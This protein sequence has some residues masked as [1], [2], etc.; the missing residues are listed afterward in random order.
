MSDLT[1]PPVTVEHH[2]EPL[3]IG[4]ATPRLSWVTRTDLPGWRQAA[5]ELEIEPEDGEAW[6]S[7]RVDSADS[8][9][10]PWGAP[11]LTS[12]ERRTVRV[13][14][15]GGGRRGAVGVERGRRR[16]GRAARRR[17]TGRPSWSS[18]SCPPSTGSRCSLL[19][20]EFVLAKPV[21]RARL[22]ATAH[23]VYEAELN[24][25]R[26]RRPRA[27]ARAGPPTSTGCATR[28][29]TSPTCSP[30]DRTRSACTLA[31]GWYRGY[32]GFAGKRRGLRRPP[33]RLRA[34][35]GRPPRRH[36]DGRHQRRLLALDPRAGDPGRHLQRRDRRPPPR[37]ARLVVSRLR[38]RRLD[39]G[40]GRVASTSRRWSPRP[41]RR[42]AARRCCRR[43]RSSTSPSGKTLVDFGQNLVGPAA[44]CAAGRPGGH[45]DHPAARRGARARRARAPARCARPRRPTS[46]SSTATGRGRGSRASPSTASATPRS[47]GWPGELTAADLEAVVVHTDLRR[48]RHVHLLGPGRQPAARERRLGHARQ[49][50]RRADRL[51]AA[52]RAAGLDRRPRG[53]RARPR[54]SSTTPPACSAPGW[55]TWP[56]SSSRTTTASS[57]SSCRSRDHAPPASRRC[58]S[59]PAGATPPS[60]CRGRCTR[61]TATPGCSP[62]SGRA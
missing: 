5:Y 16:R 22:Y 37:A 26:R 62:T 44:V 50:R 6:S 25:A 9:L 29:T 38:R 42:C 11:P 43:W 33:G 36:P 34:A 20:R 27:G 12:R 23:G 13:R 49:L 7:G 45:G 31:D 15:W 3:G 48:D 32:V 28:P 60:S 56:S 51:P 53:L 14:V 47:T 39:A 18:R 4:E 10:V 30:R 19:R 55:P 24:G 61:R 59:T 17:P 21:V 41:A 46:S 2:R 57:R 58:R 54:R 1:V 8:V 40:R 35:G 52:R